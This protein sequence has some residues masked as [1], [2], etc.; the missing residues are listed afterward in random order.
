MPEGFL[1]YNSRCREK[2][3]VS[4]PN[5]WLLTMLDTDLPAAGYSKHG[6]FIVFCRHLSWL[7][8]Q[9]N[10]L[11][12]SK[13]RKQDRNPRERRVPARLRTWEFRKRKGRNYS[14]YICASIKRCAQLVL[15]NKRRGCPMTSS[16]IQYLS[17]ANGR[18]KPPL[19]S[20]SCPPPSK[21]GEKMGRICK[22][23]PAPAL[24]LVSFIV[25]VI[26]DAI[27]VHVP[28]I[29]SRHVEVVSAVVKGS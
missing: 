23:W 17:G 20:L 4:L 10:I 7:I 6:L 28:P 14:C 19:P 1:D 21:S 3:L 12:A 24:A 9:E 26:A 13:A 22:S 25:A 27:V 29:R 2:Y 18:S 15:T 8:V 16:S 11:L 5:L